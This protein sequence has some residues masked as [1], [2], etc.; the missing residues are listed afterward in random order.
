MKTLRIK[1]VSNAEL[2]QI[3]KNKKSCQQKKQQ[4]KRAK[5]PKGI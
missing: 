5:L 3:L 2:F 1:S 4:S